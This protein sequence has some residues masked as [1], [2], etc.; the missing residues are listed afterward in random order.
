MEKEISRFIEYSQGA[1]PTKFDIKPEII[2]CYQTKQLKTPN[3]LARFLHLNKEFSKEIYIDDISSSSSNEYFVISGSG[4]TILSSNLQIEWNKGDVFILP[5]QSDYISHIP[6]E[7]ETILF[8]IDDSPLFSFLN[9]KPIT[10]R[11][12]PCYFSNEDMQS[13]LNS[14]IN[15]PNSHSKNRNGILLTTDQMINENLNTI[16]HTMWS[17]YN[18]IKPLSSQKPHKHNSV[19]FDLCVDIDEIASKNNL[20]YTLMGKNIDLQG[21]IINPKKIVWKKNHCFLTPPGWW[22][23]HHNESDKSASV[24]PIQD[25]GL[26]T[27]ME[28]LDITFS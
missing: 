15:L 16:S 7:N 21:N 1:T 2:S 9:A 24:F 12:K 8:K 13:N 10:P 20:V 14:V 28:T 25:A 19:A 5:F 23:S 22:H 6:F 18:V 11:F 4:K 3:L 17:L 27:F 26:H